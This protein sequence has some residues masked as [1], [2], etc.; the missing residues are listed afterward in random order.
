M[1]AELMNNSA[2]SYTQNGAK[3]SF[4][5]WG[6]VHLALASALDVAKTPRGICMLSP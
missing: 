3:L 6:T 2:F 4:A 1:K 5:T